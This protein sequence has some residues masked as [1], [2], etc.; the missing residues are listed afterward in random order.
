M[1]KESRLYCK[2]FALF[3]SIAD[4]EM[5]NR[6]IHRANWMRAESA[7]AAAGRG[8]PLHSALR[9]SEERSAARGSVRGR[10]CAPMTARGK[11]GRRLYGAG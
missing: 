9:T 8:E 4:Y 5:I 7:G 3:L 6:L 1:S 10:S 2:V 11:Y